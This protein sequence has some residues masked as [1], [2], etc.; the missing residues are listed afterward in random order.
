MPVTA[1]QTRVRRFGTVDG[2]GERV[3]ACTTG[4]SPG[5]VVF[6]QLSGD[7]LWQVSRTVYICICIIYYNTHK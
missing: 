1:S 4:L 7:E 3:V 6:A 5:S 2:G